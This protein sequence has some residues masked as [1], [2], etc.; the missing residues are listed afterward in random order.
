MAGVHLGIVTRAWEFVMANPREFLER[1]VREAVQ[2]TPYRNKAEGRRLT[3]ECRKAAT[4]AG[5]NWSAVIQ[6]ASGNV[7]RYILDALN[8]AADQEAEHI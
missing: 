3:Y 7:V 5:A 8:C 4:T 2:A 1:W 6:A